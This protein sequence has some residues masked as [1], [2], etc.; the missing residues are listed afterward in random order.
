MKVTIQQ[1][2]N[3]VQGIRDL[4]SAK[5]PGK[6]ALSVIRISK[7]VDA[8]LADFN[9]TRKKMIEDTGATPDDA[10]NY[11]FETP[12]AAQA[13]AMEIAGVA[14]AEVDIDHNPIPFSKLSSVDMTPSTLGAI[15]WMIDTEA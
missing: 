11:Q 9:D 8:A 3:S 4:H 15:E 14:M 12:E 6:V 10:G 13:L 1:L 7:K 2:L 5:L